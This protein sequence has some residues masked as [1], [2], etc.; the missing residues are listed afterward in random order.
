[1]LQ[2]TT[3]QRIET[4]ILLAIGCLVLAEVYQEWLLVIM[5]VG[6][7]LLSLVLPIVFHPFAFLWFGLAQVL[8]F[9]FSHLLLTVLFFLLVTPVGLFR[10]WIGKDNLQ[11]KNFKKSRQSTLIVRDHTYEASDLKNPF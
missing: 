5:A 6:L 9:F 8:S 3:R 11:L 7:L 10:K 4:G 2:I 1:M